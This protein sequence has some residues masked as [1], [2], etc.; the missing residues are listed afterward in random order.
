MF[1]HSVGTMA[2]VLLGET[3]PVHDV[4]QPAAQTGPG[5]Q[6]AGSRGPHQ[7]ELQRTRLPQTHILCYSTTGN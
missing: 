1:L 3:R 6:L 5:L 2:R 4:H 7:G